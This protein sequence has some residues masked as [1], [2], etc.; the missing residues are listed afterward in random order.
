MQWRGGM[1]QMQRPATLRE[2]VIQSLL[3]CREP[4]ATLV[5]HDDEE[6]TLPLRRPQSRATAGAHRS[7]R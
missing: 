1:A 4:A 3:A 6:P 5:D 7:S 2:F